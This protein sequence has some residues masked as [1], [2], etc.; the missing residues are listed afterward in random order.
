MRVTGGEGRHETGPDEV[1][2][3]D[4]KKEIT[5]KAR[6]RTNGEEEKGSNGAGQKR[7]GD[8]TQKTRRYPKGGSKKKRR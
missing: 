3:T 2:G 5:E 8:K 4:V 7:Q 1:C 6:K